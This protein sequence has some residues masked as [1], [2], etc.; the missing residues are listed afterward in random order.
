[1]GRRGPPKE[2]T[3]L[4]I[5]R[6][7]PSRTPIPKDEPK[8]AADNLAPPDWVTGE[9]RAKY[10]EVAGRLAALGLLTNIDVD[11]LGRY[12]VTFVEW[13]KHLVICQR[14]GDVL[15]V[16]DES[17]RLKYASVA[18]S[19]TL[20]AKH[21]QTLTRLAQEFGMTPS[22]RASLSVNGETKPNDPLSSWLQKH[23]A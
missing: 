4:R 6:G 13:K 23:H 8:P 18:P 5:L 2:P 10:E 20:V 22:S 3:P 16:K 11:A 7:N 19:A 1:M 14:G 17:G 9:A 15:Y 21:G 12:A